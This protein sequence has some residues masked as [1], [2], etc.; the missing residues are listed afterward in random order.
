MEIAW[1][2]YE[3]L[4]FQKSSDLDFSQGKLAVYGFRFKMRFSR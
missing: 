4:G 1:R 3:G 2:M